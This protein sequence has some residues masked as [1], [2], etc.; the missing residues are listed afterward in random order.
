MILND[1]LA[2]PSQQGA[3]DQNVAVQMYA[4]GAATGWYPQQPPTTQ[5]VNVQANNG[6]GNSMTNSSPA[7]T[8]SWAEYS[9]QYAQYTQWWNQQQ[10]QQATQAQSG[11][12]Q[13]FLN[14]S[15][16]YIPVCKL[17][18]NNVNIS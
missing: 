11:K 2:T 5:S 12:P 14:L 17:T 6:Q 10:A 4:P 15:Y 18:P 3:Y 7:A 1:Y 8:A 13:V 16:T 9:K